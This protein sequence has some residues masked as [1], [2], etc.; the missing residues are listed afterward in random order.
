MYAFS[1]TRCHELEW[2]RNKNGEKFVNFIYFMNPDRK[3]FSFIS[4]IWTAVLNTL[5][6]FT[7]NKLCEKAWERSVCLSDSIE[8]WN[9]Q[10]K[11]WIDDTCWASFQLTFQTNSFLLRMNREDNVNW[12]H[13]KIS[14]DTAEKLLKEGLYLSL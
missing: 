4:T 3:L 7:Y 8:W 2:N 13:G 5:H 6:F 1:N 14:R 10:E 11:F 12:F 9:V